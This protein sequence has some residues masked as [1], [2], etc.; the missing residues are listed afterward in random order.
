MEESQK[1]IDIDVEN[2]EVV[3]WVTRNNGQYTVSGIANVMFKGRRVEVDL[4]TEDFFICRRCDE[5]PLITR[6][7]IDNNMCNE[8]VKIKT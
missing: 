1:T 7:E 8:C 5:K 2:E 6:T 3:T 4:E